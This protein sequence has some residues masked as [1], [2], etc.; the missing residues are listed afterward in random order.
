MKK[1]VKENDFAKHLSYFLSKYLPGQ[2]NASSNTVASYRDT[3]KIFLNYCETEKNLK[4]ELFQMETVKK[5]LIVD[6]LDWLEIERECSISTRNQRLAAIHAFFGYVQKESPENLFEIQKILSIPTK[7]KPKPVIPFLTTDE[8]EILL[9]Q[10]DRTKES[11]QRDL[12]L[13]AV[14]YDTGARVQ[15][16]IDLTIKDIRLDK[17]AV[18]TLHGKG[19]KSRRVPIMKNTATLLNEYLKNYDGNKGCSL[20]DSPVFYNQHK[21][22]LTRRGISYILNK[23]VAMARKEEGFYNDGVITPHVLRHSRAVHMLQSGINL[24]YIRDFLGHVSVTSTEIYA[25]AD[26][27]MK[28]KALES[29]YVELDTGDLPLWEKDGELMK[30]LQ[31]LCK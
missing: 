12:V 11:G 23:Y 14:L 28:R 4:P 22:K 3:F 19:R 10:P 15:E 7:K 16:L 21:T 1:K 31:N 25:R 5:E 24:V 17:P 8:M 29:A 26:S 18:I 30:W 13:L 20:H 2:M 27:E 6:F 9:K